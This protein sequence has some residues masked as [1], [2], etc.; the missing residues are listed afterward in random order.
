MKPTKQPHALFTEFIFKRE[1][2]KYS[3]AA[4]QQP[5]TLQLTKTETPNDGRFQPQQLTETQVPNCLSGDMKIVEVGQVEQVMTADKMAEVAI[6]VLCA[7][8]LVTM[9]SLTEFSIA[10]A[11]GYAELANQWDNAKARA[12]L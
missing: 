9:S 8:M 10:S 12:A 1:F 4:L 11:D 3:A 2:S 7:G 6:R 5:K